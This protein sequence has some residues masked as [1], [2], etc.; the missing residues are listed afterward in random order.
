[1][2]TILGFVLTPVFHL[3]MVSLIVAFY[4]VQVVAR[5]FFGDYSR[6]KSVDLLNILLLR[7]LHIIGARVKYLGLENL[8]SNR[9]V[10]VVS[11]HQSMYDIPAIGWS[12][13]KYY[14]KFISKIELSK[15]MFSISYNLKHGKSALIDRKN[16]SQSVKEILKLGRLI[17]KNNYAACIFP[18]GTRSKTGRLRPF[19]SAGIQSLLRGAPSAVVVPFVISGHNR[20]LEKGNFPLKFGEEITYQILEPIE[21]QDHSAEEITHHLQKTIE[22]HLR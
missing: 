9:P 20:I 1:M 3:Y 17:E 13:R 22:K 11:N 12:F 6:R 14:P 2:K 18:E 15:N 4:P 10:I 5:R 19:M 16:G 7:G 21:P 8:P